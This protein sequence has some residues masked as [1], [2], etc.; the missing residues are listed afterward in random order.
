[1]AQLLTLNL[2]VCLTAWYLS[3]WAVSG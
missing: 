1:M 2:H 3:L